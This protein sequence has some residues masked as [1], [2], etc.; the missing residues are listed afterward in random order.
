MGC[1]VL[2]SIIQEGGSVMYSQLDL[3]DLRTR[4]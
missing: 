4:N 3:E 2:I 1:D